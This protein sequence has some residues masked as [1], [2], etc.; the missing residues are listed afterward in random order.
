VTTLL[1]LSIGQRGRVAAIAG[2][3]ALS[4][5]LME[6]GLVPGVELQLIGRAPLGDPLEFDVLGY[7]LSIRKSEA[8]RVT[9][10]V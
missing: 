9:I 10:Q 3:D 5:R 8:V 6:M 1:D 7:R 4:Q 2:N